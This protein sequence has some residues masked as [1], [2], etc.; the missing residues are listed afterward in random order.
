MYA[1]R[2]K[3]RNHGILD[4]STKM[5]LEVY[6]PSLSITALLAVT[7]YILSDAVDVIKQGE[8]DDDVNVYFLFAFAGGNF[9]VDIVSSFMFY[10]RGKEVL[11]SSPIS[12]DRLSVHA[13]RTVSQTES[14]TLPSEPKTT[15]NLNMI[16]ALT[17]VGSDTLRTMS[18]FVAAVISYAG[19]QNSS[20]CD[21][22]A[23]VVV[24]ITIVF[25]VIPLL[26][27]IYHVIQTTRTE[28]PDVGNNNSEDMYNSM[29]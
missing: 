17:H 6:I 25:A 26:K 1:E 8:S 2:V 4:K 27:E 13:A 9:L 29:M 20:L 3:A 7:G 14:K 15:P 16:S 5:L 24:S 12:H 28:N 22:W 18:V 19:H 21:A 11:L 10:W 23:A